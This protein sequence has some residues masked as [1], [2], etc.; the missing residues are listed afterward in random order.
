ML[1]FFVVPTFV[2]VLGC[3]FIP[4]VVFIC[5]GDIVSCWLF[6]VLAFALVGVCEKV[7]LIFF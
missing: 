3:V 5:V 2:V 6:A 4:R 1:W 7:I